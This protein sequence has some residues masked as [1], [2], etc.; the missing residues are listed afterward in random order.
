MMI[1][2]G[3]VF[4]EESDFTLHRPIRDRIAALEHGLA[5][6]LRERG[7]QVLGSH[8]SAEQPNPDLLDKIIKV[9]EEQLQKKRID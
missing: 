2:I 8:S 9:A 4:P 1:A 7:Y 6:H 5:Q 3:P